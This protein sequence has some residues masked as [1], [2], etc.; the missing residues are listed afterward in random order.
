MSGSLFDVTVS[1]VV[2][3]TFEQRYPVDQAVRVIADRAR[4]GMVA[5]G[6][7][8]LWVGDDGVRSDL[9]YVFDGSPDGLRDVAAVSSML[10][11]WPHDVSF[12]VEVLLMR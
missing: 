1:G 12:C 7:E 10:D 3:E 6:I 11:S 2:S 4:S 9:D 5:I 8:G